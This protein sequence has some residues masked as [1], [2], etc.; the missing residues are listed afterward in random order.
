[1]SP[2]EM[3]ML[4]AAGS[5]CLVCKASELDIPQIVSCL[6]MIHKLCFRPKGSYDEGKWHGNSLLQDLGSC[7]LH[8]SGL[9]HPE[10]KKKKNKKE[11]SI[12]RSVLLCNRP[13]VIESDKFDYL[14]GIFSILM[15]DHLNAKHRD[16]NFGFITTIGL[17]PRKSANEN[18]FNCER[19][20][21]WHF[22]TKTISSTL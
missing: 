1:M 17:L 12:I 3:Q 13:L 11:N 7:T 21:P 18:S 16:W 19:N 10:E 20:F 9:R 14:R 4:L 15:L 6:T 8:F 2:T 5:S 22:L